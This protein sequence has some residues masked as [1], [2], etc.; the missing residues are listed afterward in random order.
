M[1]ILRRKGSFDFLNFALL[2]KNNL[3][4]V[5]MIL[6]ETLGALLVD[7]ANKEYS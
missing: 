1:F 6:K 4:V 3:L 7:Y 2:D 5:V